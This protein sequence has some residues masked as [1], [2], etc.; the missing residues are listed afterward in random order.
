MPFPHKKSV[1]LLMR[2]F[3]R[4]TCVFTKHVWITFSTP[5]PIIAAAPNFWHHT[6][7][8]QRKLITNLICFENICENDKW[9][10]HI[11]VQL[12]IH[13]IWSFQCSCTAIKT[14]VSNDL[15]A[16]HHHYSLL[17]TVLYSNRDK[18]NAAP[19]ADEAYYRDKWTMFG[20]EAEAMEI[21]VIKNQRLL[22]TRVNK[23]ALR[24]EVKSQLCSYKWP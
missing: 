24:K 12:S 15:Y 8:F 9:N 17:K 13:V 6:E 16:L 11:N 4:L 18:L 2:F 10:L 22:R 1:K 5:S 23:M 14:Y 19:A 21:A 7:K 3:H 20:N